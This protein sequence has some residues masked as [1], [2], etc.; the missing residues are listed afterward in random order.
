MDMIYWLCFIV[1]GIFVL[2]SVVGGLDGADIA[3]FDTD[4]DADVDGDFDAEAGVEMSADPDLDLELRDPGDAPTGPRRFWSK[5]A[6]RSSPLSL[7]TSFKFWTFGSCFFGLTGLVL[8]ALGLMPTFV[9]I[10][11]LVMGFICGAGMAL[12]LRQLRRRQVNSL[13]QSAD[14]A[15]L[16]GTVEIPFDAS[17]RGKVRLQVKGSTV[18]FIA[19][20]NDST[21]LDAGDRV[22]VIGT[23]NNRLWVVPANKPT[24]S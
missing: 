12:T 19:Y 18:D 24:L 17:T 20:T 13:V 14:L 3:D 9:A 21:P 23:E 2:L 11:A 22:F 15:G 8:S 16:E 1:G 5:R 10:A 7:L 4:F 6:R